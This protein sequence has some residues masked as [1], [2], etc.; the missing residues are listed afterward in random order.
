VI[1]HIRPDK[2]S[3]NFIGTRMNAL[4]ILSPHRD[5]VVF[6]LAFFL[7]RVKALQV[8][9]TALNVFTRS[10]YG[11][12]SAIS[13]EQDRNRC[14]RISILREREDRRAFRI[15]NPRV[16]VLDQG[17][18]DAPIRRQTRVER[19]LGPGSVPVL[20]T[21]VSLLARALSPHII[22]SLVLCP[23]GLGG[24]VDHL[25]VRA[26][27]LRICPSPR[28]AFY[29]DS[30]YVRWTSRDEMLRRLNETGLELRSYLIRTNQTSRY[31][32]HLAAQYQSQISAEEADTISRN[33]S[34]VHPGETIWAPAHSA[35]WVRILRS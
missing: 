17:F 16:R 33:R 25:T 3:A 21:E 4:T 9:I 20:E 28:L 35:N 11:P 26:A 10:D 24:H 31:K 7:S 12:R 29:E 23:L 8:R 19:V 1:E 14:S 5:D 15:L 13:N 32:A 18:L 30:P 22:R 27:A 6:S 34:R 2:K